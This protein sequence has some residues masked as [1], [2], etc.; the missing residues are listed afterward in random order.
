MADKFNLDGFAV[1]DE[2]VCTAD[3]GFVG[4]LTG[5]IAGT[6]TTYI[7]DG[8]I[9]LLDT[10]VLLSSVSATVHLDLADGTFIGQEILL[11]GSVII[12]AA[13]VTLTNPVTA[14][15]DVL[16]FTSGDAT[17]VRWTSS[18]WAVIQ[19]VSVA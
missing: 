4:I 18:G 19:G 12:S 14:A 1:S 3:G 13:T 16:T 5:N 7:A 6:E 11:V 17:I 8:D 9:S 10:V 15:T 2:N